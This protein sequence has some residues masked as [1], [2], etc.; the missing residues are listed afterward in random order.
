LDPNGD[1]NFEAEYRVSGVDGVERWVSVRGRTR[2]VDGKAVSH[3]GV[4]VDVTKRRRDEEAV[5]QKAEELRAV[6]DAA[7]V[8]VWVAHDPECRVITGNAYADELIMGTARGANISMSAPAGEAAVNYRVF[9]E[10]VELRP[11]QMPAQRS[12]ATKKPVPAFAM[13]LVF[14]DGRKLS[15]MAG[16]VP[17]FNAAGAVRGAIVAGLDVTPLKN[18]EEGLRQAEERARLA[19]QAGRMGTWDRMMPNGPTVWNED[20]YRILGYDS[21]QIAPSNKAW[22]ARV[23]P[24]DLRAFY[25]HLSGV[26]K[27]G[28]DFSEELRILWPDSSVR[29]VELRGSIQC[30]ANGQPKRSFGV[31]L[32]FTDRRRAELALRETEEHFRSITDTTPVIM[33][34]TNATGGLEFVNRAYREFFGVTLEQVAG[35][36]RWQPPVH[37][38]DAEQYVGACM[39]ALSKRG[40]FVAEARLRRADGQWRWIQSFGAPRFNEEGEFL[41]LAGSSPDVTERKEFQAELERLVAE[42]TNKLQELVGEL[43]HFSY[44][45]THDLKSPLRAMRGFA[46]LVGVTCGE[47]ER[48]Q[49]RQ[50][51]GKISSSAERM[52]H[53]IADALNY[54]RSVRQELPLEDVD[55]GALLRGIL[56]SYPE[57]QPDK[58]RIRVEGQLPVVLANEAGLTQCFSNLLGNAVKFVPAGET[59][60]IRVWASGREGWVR[61]WVE[62]KGIGIAKEIL[63]R[64][65]DMFM[66]GSKD[67]EGTGIGLALVR[68]VAQRMGGR[69]GVESEEGKGSR[70]WLELKSGED[71]RSRG[72][73][74]TSTL[75]RGA[76]GMVLYVE[77]EESDAMFMERAF[78][79]KG[80]SGKLRVVGDGRQAIDYLSRSGDYSDREKYPVP[81]LVLLD[82]NLPHV[83]GFQ[84][85][86]WM[87]NNPDYA[88]TPVVVFSSSTREDDR[89]KARE[90]G[91]SEFVSKPNSGMRF[92]Q[93][94][95]ELR[96]KWMTG[97]G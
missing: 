28:G 30:D 91:A 81:A 57:L 13:E 17:L 86:E 21:A 54:S 93:V 70:F 79:A 37:P 23:H 50:F 83:P 16:A 26:R 52:D 10:G 33:W 82:L 80:L 94:V 55:A 29:W 97:V 66:R 11:E 85:L 51:L 12:T 46:E 19:L 4:A 14:A 96:G 45:I 2:F 8:A 88:Q 22:A 68:K 92:G 18:A 95:E 40:P 9:R 59:P 6:L 75:A 27:H 1:G 38:E 67:Y 43:E 87:R 58:A 60:E 36:G 78:A 77:D 71:K 20:H 49:A 48:G 34:M 56:D 24:D 89:V 25:K 41:G 31:V 3:T 69:V 15:L 74:A 5:R 35:P 44:T 64:V 53:L 61:I 7:P 32:D 42:R 63:P 65:F 73:A 76:E 72:L 84:V 39:E 90:L 62:D 47:C